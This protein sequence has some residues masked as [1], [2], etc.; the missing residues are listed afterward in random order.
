MLLAWFSFF[1]SVVGFIVEQF[2]NCCIFLMRSELSFGIFVARKNGL[3]TTILM[4][5]AFIGKP[6][7]LPED[8]EGR[9][10]AA[11]AAIFCLI[12]SPGAS[13]CRRSR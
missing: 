12:D 8:A 9:S 4:E 1:F 2:A 11:A 10:S 6:S 5:A 13:R 7:R 3:S